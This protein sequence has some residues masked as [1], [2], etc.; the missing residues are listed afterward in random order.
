M[1]SMSEPTISRTIEDTFLT[2]EAPD[3]RRWILEGRLEDLTLDFKTAPKS[4]ETGEER[5]VLAKAISGFSNSSGGLVVWGVDARRDRASGIESAVEAPLA[6]PDLL[7][8]NLVRHSAVVVSP[9]ATRVA[10]RLVASREF[11]LTYIPET[12]GP[13]H[14]S[15]VEHRYFKRSGESFYPMEHYDIADMFGRRAQPLLRPVFR[16]KANGL[17]VGLENIGRGVATAPYLAVRVP[18]EFTSAGHG[19]DGNGNYGLNKLPPSSSQRETFG[20]STTTVIHPG[21]TLAVTRFPPRVR[22]V[23]GPV[24]RKPVVIEFSFACVGMPLTSG[25][26]TLEPSK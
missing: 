9:S 10:H 3:V 12:D 11:A 13:P 15:N 6:D 22:T 16:L 21:Q 5:K 2:L 8:S 24:L 17:L 26:E 7:L 4:L 25:K 1:E 19:V 20:D 18:D 23:D 14:M